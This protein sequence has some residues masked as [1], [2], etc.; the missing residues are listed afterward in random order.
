VNRWP[1]KLRAATASDYQ[2]ILGLIDGA[3][4]W[5]SSKGTDQWAKPWPDEQGR[6][7]RV[8]DDLLEGKTWLAMDDAKVAATI[9]IDPTDARI[10]PA[11]KRED[12]AVYVRRVIVDRD[13]GGREVGACLLNWASDIGVSIHRA[14]WVRVNVWTTNFDLHAYYRA[15]NF[16]FVGLHDLADEPAYPSRAL[17]QRSTTQRRPDYRST[18]QPVE[19]VEW[20]RPER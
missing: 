8:R 17:F 6:N 1:L 13:Y 15:Q 2:N 18:L 16:E 20:L 3:A 10:W 5:L 14:L 19:D 12:P 7:A 11:D 4:R 9:T